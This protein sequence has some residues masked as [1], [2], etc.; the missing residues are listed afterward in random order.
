MSTQVNTPQS[1]FVWNDQVLFADFDNHRVRKILPNGSTVTIA[2]TGV[3]GY[4]GDD[5][6][7]TMAQLD[8][9]CCVFVS[10]RG[11]VYIGED[12]RVRK[13]L[14]NGNI[15]TVA[16]TGDEGYNGDSRLATDA[17]IVPFGIFVSS[18][19]EIYIADYG[20]HRIRKVLQNGMIVTIAGTGVEGYNEDNI[21]AINAQLSFPSG[22]FVSDSN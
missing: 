3:A 17:W 8:Y 15:V 22:V 11:E 9:P 16:G 19:D 2:G 14:T 13:I 5:Q 20:N 12:R 1:V 18:D 10:E 6:L 7:A 4:N 21:L